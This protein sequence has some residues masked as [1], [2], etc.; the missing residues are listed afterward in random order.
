MRIRGQNKELSLIH[1]RKSDNTAWESIWL[2]IDKCHLGILL[3]L[4]ELHQALGTSD[5]R[6]QDGPCSEHGRA[7]L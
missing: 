7:H 1:V 2:S 4:H 6:V 3:W 5:S